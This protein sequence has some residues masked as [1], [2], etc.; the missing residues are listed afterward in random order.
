MKNKT[1]TLLRFFYRWY[2]ITVRT[3]LLSKAAYFLISNSFFL[4]FF[5][6]IYPFLPLNLNYLLDFGLCLYYSFFDFFAPPFDP[7]KEE[8]RC[9]FGIGSF[10]SS[11]AFLGL[12]VALLRIRNYVNS[13]FLWLRLLWLR[14]STYYKERRPTAFGLRIGRKIFNIFK[15]FIIILILILSIYNKTKIFSF[16]LLCT[17]LEFNNLISLYTHLLKS[18]L[19]TGLIKVPLPLEGTFFYGTNESFPLGSEGGVKNFS[20]SQ[21]LNSSDLNNNTSV[22]EGEGTV[23]ISTSNNSSTTTYPLPPQTPLYP[24]LQFPLAP[25]PSQLPPYWGVGEGGVGEAGLEGKGEKEVELTTSTSSAF[26][27]SSAVSTHSEFLPP[28]SSSTTNFLNKIGNL[29]ELK[30][31][32][33]HLLDQTQK[34]DYIQAK[35]YQKG[36][37]FN[38]PSLDWIIEKINKTDGTITSVDNTINSNLNSILKIERE[39]KLNSHSFKRIRPFLLGKDYS[40]SPTQIPN[41]VPYKTPSNFED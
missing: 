29:T 18:N 6:E 26:S 39:A 5:I 8:G 4:I 40:S 7:V 28:S 27:A 19:L 24:E 35:F 36:M 37:D 17:S 22:S 31:S 38:T 21:S 14:P 30:F 1:L 20:M 13:C 34:Y 33:F 9:G 23:E 2:R 15:I 41:T 25:L 12:R 16:L 3:V 11:L 10:Y 32:N